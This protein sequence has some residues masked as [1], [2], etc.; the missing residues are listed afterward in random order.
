MW[1]GLPAFVSLSPLILYTHKMDSN[2]SSCHFVALRELYISQALK[3]LYSSNMINGFPQNQNS[4]ERLLS[5]NGS[6]LSSS[7]VQEIHRGP[8]FHMAPTAEA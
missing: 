5:Q 2:L 4:S 6:K 3:P 8:D 7:C 1:E